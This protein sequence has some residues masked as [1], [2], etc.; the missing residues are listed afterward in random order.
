MLIGWYDHGSSSLIGED[1]MRRC[2]LWSTSTWSFDCFSTISHVAIAG[3]PDGWDERY[4]WMVR[5]VFTG[6]GKPHVCSFRLELSGEFRSENGSHFGFKTHVAMFELEAN[7]G[8]PTPGAGFSRWYSSWYHPRGN[9]LKVTLEIHQVL[10]I[11]LKTAKGAVV[12]FGTM[13]PWGHRAISPEKKIR[14][15]E[16]VS[17]DARRW[18]FEMAHFLL[19]DVATGVEFGCCLSFSRCLLGCWHLVCLMATV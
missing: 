12:D 9:L 3:G 7:M 1:W 15:P 8:F 2:I 17:A 10:W 16:K 19:V 4:I 13:S 5:R 18:V 11:P 6:G 14:A